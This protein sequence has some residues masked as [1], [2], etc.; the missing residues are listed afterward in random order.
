[1]PRENKNMATRG[2]AASA[3]M[4]ALNTTAPKK[5]PTAPGTASGQTLAQSTFPNRQCEAPDAAVVP[6]S[7]MCTLADASAGAMPTANN[8]LWDV[9]P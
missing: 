3:V 9:T 2:S 1:M 5:A 7:A 8:R 4:N 6:T